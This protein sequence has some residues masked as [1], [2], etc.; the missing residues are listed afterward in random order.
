MP[1]REQREAVASC[2][3]YK[4]TSDPPKT[5]LTYPKPTR[6]N[7]PP[8]DIDYK[9]ILMQ[10]LILDMEFQG[11][12][13]RSLVLVS[14]DQNK[15]Y[16]YE[17]DG[18][19]TF[20]TRKPET[21]FFKIER[22]VERIS[23]KDAARL[24]FDNPVVVNDYQDINM[25]K[26]NCFYTKYLH[27]MANNVK[28]THIL[29]ANVC[30]VYQLHHAKLRS[31]EPSIH[32]SLTAAL[33]YY[34]IEALK[35]SDSWD[36]VRTAAKPLMGK[37]LKTPLTFQLLYEESRDGTLMAIKGGTIRK[38]S[39]GKLITP[40][41]F[42]NLDA[43]IQLTPT[44]LEEFI[45][46]A[47]QEAYSPK[48]IANWMRSLEIHNPIP[49]QRNK[50][51]GPASQLVGMYGGEGSMNPNPP[52]MQK[53]DFNFFGPSEEA[54]EMN[55][56]EDKRDPGILPG[57]T[58]N[59]Q[60]QP[61][62]PIKR[63]AKR[64]T[65]IVY[66][67]KTTSPPAQEPQPPSIVLKDGEIIF[68]NGPPLS[69]G[70][71]PP[72]L[73]PFKAERF[74]VNPQLHYAQLVYD[75]AD[76]ARAYDQN[77]RNKYYGA[78]N[79][80]CAKRL[81]SFLHESPLD[82]TSFDN[83]VPRDQD[84]YMTRQYTTQDL[85]SILPKSSIVLTREAHEHLPTSIKGY[86]QIATEPHLFVLD[87]TREGF[88]IL[89]KQSY[90]LMENTNEFL[91]AIR[92]L[93]TA[94]SHPA[95]M[96]TWNGF[97][98]PLQD[99]E[100]KYLVQ[101]YPLLVK[102]PEN[103]FYSHQW[104]SYKQLE[105]RTSEE[106]GDYY[107]VNDATVTIPQ[108]KQTVPC[109]PPKYE[110]KK[111]YM[112]LAKN[113]IVIDEI[114]GRYEVIHWSSNYQYKDGKIP[115]E[116]EAEDALHQYVQRYRDPDKI[117]RRNPHAFQ[118][119]FTNY[120]MTE[121][122]LTLLN[123]SSWKILDIGSKFL[124]M[125]KVCG[126]RLIAVR[127]NT[128]TSGDQAY[129][130][131]VIDRE[132]LENGASICIKKCLDKDSPL[133]E[134]VN[135]LSVDS[136]YYPGVAE[137]IEK[138]LAT[139]RKVLCVFQSYDHIV[140]DHQLKYNGGRYQIYVKN[141]KIWVSAV[142]RE[143]YEPYTHEVINPPNCGSNPTSFNWKGLHFHILKSTK[144]SRYSSV[145]YA[146]I[147]KICRYQEPLKTPANLTKIERQIEYYVASKLPPS[148]EIPKTMH[149]DLFKYLSFANSVQ[150][151]GSLPGF[152]AD[153]VTLAIENVNTK[154]RNSYYSQK[155][156]KW[157][158]SINRYEHIHDMKI[159]SN[160]DHF[161]FIVA[162]VIFFGASF[163]EQV[164]I[165]ALVLLVL[166]VMAFLNYMK[167]H[168]LQVNCEIEHS[169]LR[170][171]AHPKP[172]KLV[173]TCLV[174]KAVKKL[175]ASRGLFQLDEEMKG[176]FTALKD[177]KYCRFPLMLQ[178]HE[179]TLFPNMH[180]PK[181]EYVREEA[182]YNL[183]FD[184]L[185]T[186][187]R[188][189]INK[190]R[191]PIV[192]DVVGFSP[193]T[194]PP[195]NPDLIEFRK[196]KSDLSTNPNRT[197]QSLKVYDQNGHEVS[198]QNITYI[199]MKY[200]PYKNTAN[201]FPNAGP[202]KLPSRWGPCA[203]N[204]LHALLNR[205]AGTRMKPDLS[206]VSD[207]EEFAKPFIK[208][209]CRQYTYMDIE[210]MD[211]QGFV[212]KFPPNKRKLMEQGRKDIMDWKCNP[213]FEAMVKANEY[214][215]CVEG[216][217]KQLTRPRIIFCPSAA[218]RALHGV[219]NAHILKALK[220]TWHKDNQLIAAYGYNCEE[221]AS[222]IKHAQKSI[223]KTSFFGY[224][225]SS[226]DANQHVELIKAVDCN[227]HREFLPCYG[228][229]QKPDLQEYL[230]LARHLTSTIVPFKAYYPGTRNILARGK[231]NGTVFTG[232]PTR[233]TF[234]NTLRIGLFLKYALRTLPANDWRALIG[235]DDV[236]LIIK[237]GTGQKVHRLLTNCFM[238][239]SHYDS[240]TGPQKYGLGQVIK[241][242]AQLE[243]NIVNF[244]SKQG[245]Y[246]L[247]KL[248]YSRQFARS[249]LSNGTAKLRKNFTKKDHAT[250]VTFSLSTFG[251]MPIIKE[252]IT[253][254]LRKG[255]GG[256]P[257]IEH[258]PEHHK[259]WKNSKL[260]KDLEPVY[261]GVLGIYYSTAIDFFD[262]NCPRAM[263]LC[264][265]LLSTIL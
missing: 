39:K 187:H 258:L 121:A 95:I 146:E 1:L 31:I 62:G 188:S 120:Y 21:Y 209:I 163:I 161:T 59:S 256:D 217:P 240:S 112:K 123:T 179:N 18:P 113:D 246:V 66:K 102:T 192:T 76:P 51:F 196:K 73:L 254:R 130:Q 49:I 29:E 16:I 58:H 70:Q 151:I 111:V 242:Q 24:I 250:N 230:L 183:D 265:Q 129:H 243:N 262:P 201:M 143:N 221:T 261:R 50:V 214:N 56:E 184:V 12:I 193:Y 131:Q 115:K 75:G 86:P 170:Y 46:I 3:P 26:L 44:P 138:C 133:A 77:T 160:S 229:R 155:M 166:T 205:N 4:H 213:T 142:T 116:I 227:F 191:M 118:R 153:D 212:N 198:K 105:V 167:T 30:K 174:R 124:Q 9:E 207:F 157:L 199:P 234:G 7:Q 200:H 60:S 15:A 54:K 158:K 33:A 249:C 145:C 38:N 232:H 190:Y 71:H 87:H 220:E 53:H 108:I 97:D 104:Q 141:R 92:A 244:L 69:T 19:F 93:F 165:P 22:E 253:A 171:P 238:T 132:I 177:W 23:R 225:G 91:N 117:P 159:K 114:N 90:N 152:N 223:G 127:G 222:L 154:I 52:P 178:D 100:I 78:L 264:D 98:G 57:L 206:M 41:L 101:H 203:E 148:T 211:W 13:L 107:V 68:S 89:L 47:N 168:E 180:Q 36:L 162:I 64:N 208:E 122:V 226:H 224:D 189:Q 48:M 84:P 149:Q 85:F 202:E 181:V 245:F 88:H 119:T 144:M 228:I 99:E 28:E 81:V 82:M 11:E 96:R 45:K 110:K 43:R 55:E 126:E 237:K 236:L 195:I 40:F 37:I 182:D 135:I 103:T 210:G 25:M 65:N 136:I 259:L 156:T 175:I 128:W 164:R 248:I 263:K 8:Q 14:H 252:Y 140:G 150:S 109:H 173:E 72:L 63:N 185:A 35:L 83:Y 106:D 137:Y 67:K 2:S 239:K 216:D 6:I 231:V 194:E 134:N 219:Y 80:E 251:E 241:E 257:K 20:D 204:L 255:L 5:P 260:P 215:F 61:E 32:S 79:G 17:V 74:T 169:D 247:D 233:T 27:V 172:Y 10:S 34:Y 218:Y 139:P 186:M 147:S 235:G 42:N 176:L 94:D 197:L 125:Y